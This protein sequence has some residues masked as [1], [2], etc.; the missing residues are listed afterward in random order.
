ME[1]NL[2]EAIIEGIQ[3]KKG[4]KIVVIDMDK[5]D[6]AVCRF[7]VVCEGNSPQQVEAIADSVEEFARIK[8]G[9]K[10][11]HVVGVGLS[12]W[13]AMDYADV[14]VHVFLPDVREYY[15]LEHLWGDAKLT[16]VADL[17]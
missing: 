9:E 17:D 1:K 7:F 16:E 12:Q 6:G 8:A 13:V 15:D 10:P 5:I 2:V 3:E 4:H 14:M 11:I